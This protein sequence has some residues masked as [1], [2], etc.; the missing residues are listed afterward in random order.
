MILHVF[1]YI[2]ADHQVKMRAWQFSRN[3]IECADQY[4]IQHGFCDS[5]RYRRR[6]HSSISI[7]L[8]QVGAEQPLSAAYLENAF[9]PFR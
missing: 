2:I 1:N 9:I 4:M 6:L 7:V 5:R 8:F 3:L